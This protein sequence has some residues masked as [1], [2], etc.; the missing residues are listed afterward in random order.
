MPKACARARAVRVLLAAALGVVCLAQQTMPDHNA[1]VI[2]QIGQLSA[3]SDNGLRALSIGDAVRPQQ[4]IVTG[5][6][7]YGQFKLADGSTFEVFANSQVMFREHPGKL[8]DIL[9]VIIGHI[10]VY[11]QHN[12]NGLPNYNRVES[13]TAVIS[14]RGTVY[15]VVVED[16]DGTTYVQVEEGVVG[17][18]N[19]TAP[20]GEIQLHP[21]DAI[22]VIRNQPLQARGINQGGILRNV[23]RAAEDAVYQVARQSGGIGRLPGTTV[24]PAPTGNGDTGKGSG[25]GSAPSAPG[26]P[27]Q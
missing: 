25:G 10:K 12:L 15:E 19:Q 22:R 24:S 13:P 20:G 21:G 8:D 3:L 5:P 6:D 23:L 9:N 1:K 7:G 4:I 17:V 16:V 11:I 2:F 27:H 26:A 18:L 14:V